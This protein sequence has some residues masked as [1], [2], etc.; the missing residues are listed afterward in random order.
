MC[1]VVVWVELLKI[2]DTETGGDT[3]VGNV[4]WLAASGRRTDYCQ[5]VNLAHYSRLVSH[6]DESQSAKLMCGKLTIC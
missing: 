6:F 4:W 3:E 1:D 2:F 5:Y